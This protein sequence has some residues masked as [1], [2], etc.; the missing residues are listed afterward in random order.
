MEHIAEQAGTSGLLSVFDN[1]MVEKQTSVTETDRAYCER[2]Q[3]ALYLALD[4]IERWYDIFR[5]EAGRESRD[6]HREAMGNGTPDSR[7]PCAGR[8]TP[9]PEPRYERLEFRPSEFIDK[10][11]ENYAEAVGLFGK[12]I[13]TYF[14]RT[15]GVSVPEPEFDEN[16]I[17]IGFRPR[18]QTYVDLVLEH[19]GGREFGDVA[20]REALERF[21]RFIWPKGWRSPRQYELKGDT[22]RFHRILYYDDFYIKLNGRNHLRYN[23]DRELGAV[24]EGVAFGAAGKPGG[25]SIIRDFDGSDVS[26]TRWCDLDA[27]AATGMRFYLNGRID[28]RFTD[29]YEA[30]KCYTKL[31]LDDLSSSP[32]HGNER[33]VG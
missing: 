30:R 12:A 1:I 9:E 19:L 2:Q 7:D 6:H 21:R 20:G 14:N 10:L 4:K 11:S 26:L 13:V 17:A 23:Y 16:N 18:Y 29:K 3:E 15:Y 24:C 22:I 31:G 32:G 28:V 27:G 8:A 5:Q 33:C 25:R